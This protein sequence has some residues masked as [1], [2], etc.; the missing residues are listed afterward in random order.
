MRSVGYLHELKGGLK[1]FHGV[2]LD[3]EELHAHDE[4]DDALEH[5]GTLLLLPQLLQLRDEL[6]PHR[7]EP[8]EYTHTQSMRMGQVMPRCLPAN[9]R[10]GL[11][12]KVPNPKMANNNKIINKI[13]SCSQGIFNRQEVKSILFVYPWKTKLQDGQQAKDWA[14]D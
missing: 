13:I 9:I 3:S 4:A 10:L 2:H 11:R 8:G 5:V 12:L 7:L 6:L 1:V 14:L